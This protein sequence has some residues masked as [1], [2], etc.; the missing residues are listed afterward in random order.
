M[1][2]WHWIIVLYV[3]PLIVNSL[4]LIKGDTNVETIGDFLDAYVLYLVPVFNLVLSILL[5]IAF[6]LD[7]MNAQERWE[8]FKN[9]KIK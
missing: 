9:I 2:I 7:K 3:L 6:I 8:K 4:Y 5:P 1:E